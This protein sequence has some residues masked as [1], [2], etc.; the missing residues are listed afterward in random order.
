MKWSE[1]LLAFFHRNEVKIWTIKIWSWTTVQLWSCYYVIEWCVAGTYRAWVMWIASFHYAG[2]ILSHQDVLITL[3]PETEHT[4]TKCLILGTPEMCNKLPF[5]HP[6]VSCM[7]YHNTHG[8]ISLRGLTYFPFN[9]LWMLLVTSS[10][11]L[12]IVLKSV[13]IRV[14]TS[15]D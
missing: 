1:T 13:A 4:S 5:F 7:G 9:R 11:H 6:S 14:K 2:T 3:S 12:K 15:H 8:P 10:Q